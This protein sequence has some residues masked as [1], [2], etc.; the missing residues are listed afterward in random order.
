VQN[1]GQIVFIL[2]V[3]VG[4]SKCPL[5]VTVRVLASLKPQTLNKLLICSLIAVHKPEYSF[6]LV[7]TGF[8]INE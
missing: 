2:T 7:I 5:L 3:S 1:N 6:A 8:L 4:T